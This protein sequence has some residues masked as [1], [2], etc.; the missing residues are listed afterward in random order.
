MFLRVS[1]LI[2]KEILWMLKKKREYFR[3]N[4]LIIKK[5][6]A[7]LANITGIILKSKYN[8]IIFKKMYK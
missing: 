7:N 6:F 4:A 8:S 2:K 3:H 1:G 5:I